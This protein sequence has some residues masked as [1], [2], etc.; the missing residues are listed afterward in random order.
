S[1]ACGNNN[2]VHAEINP[3]A[4]FDIRSAFEAQFDHLEDGDL[5]MHVFNSPA[6]GK[7]V[8]VYGPWVT[9]GNHGHRPEI[10]P[11]ELIWW[12]QQ[13][14]IPREGLFTT[15]GDRIL[16]L[17]Y[18]HVAIQ[19]DASNRFDL[20]GYFPNK[21]DFLSCGFDGSEFSCPTY[22]GWTRPWAGPPRKSQLRI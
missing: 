6:V 1:V 2:C 14:E 12:R 21:T 20:D 22:P 9:D 3:P 7:D 18:L 8:C 5:S 4:N 19:Q 13:R 10:H 15:D 11:A 17:D 16:S